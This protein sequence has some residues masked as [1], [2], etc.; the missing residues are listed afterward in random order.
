MK[1]LTKAELID[2]IERT[3]P[4]DAKVLGYS[5]MAGDFYELEQE[6]V[7]LFTPIENYAEEDQED[8]SGATHV[9]EQI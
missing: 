7:S 2:Y 8:F 4:E 9:L 3:L 5:S 1:A 6:D